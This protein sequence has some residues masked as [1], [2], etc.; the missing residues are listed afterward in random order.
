[1]TSIAL[2]LPNPTTPPWH[3]AKNLL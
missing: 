3:Y 2:I 1:M